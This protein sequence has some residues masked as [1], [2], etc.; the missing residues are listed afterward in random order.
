MDTNHEAALKAERKRVTRCFHR[1][2]SETRADL[3]ASFRLGYQQRLSTGDFFY[4]HP[5]FPN[6]AFRTQ[7]EAARA[8]LRAAS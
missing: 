5:A 8:A 7:G 3:A 1:H 4:V 2:S 6:T